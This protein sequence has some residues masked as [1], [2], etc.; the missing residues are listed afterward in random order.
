MTLNFLCDIQN[1]HLCEL[2]KSKQIF[3]KGGEK[4]KKKHMEVVLSF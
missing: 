4:P 3:E 2:L 1:S